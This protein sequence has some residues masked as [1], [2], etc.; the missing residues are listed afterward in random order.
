MQVLPLACV[1]KP[2][3]KAEEG[4]ARGSVAGGGGG[5]TARERES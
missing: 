2:H 1:Y 4:V 5:Y 3:D